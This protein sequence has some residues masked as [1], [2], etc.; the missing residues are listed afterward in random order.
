M[1][2]HVFPALAIAGKIELPQF[3]SVPTVALHGDDR[4]MT[5][6]LGGYDDQQRSSA[7]G[8]LIEA[9]H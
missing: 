4:V 8:A 3:P 6:W 7:H 9:N 2:S 5:E 1:G